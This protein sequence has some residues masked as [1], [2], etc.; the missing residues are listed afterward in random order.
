MTDLVSIPAV[1]Q[2]V[3]AINTA[4]RSAESVTRQIT[5]L[6]SMETTAPAVQTES[7]RATNPTPVSKGYDRRGEVE[8]EEEPTGERISFVA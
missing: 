2:P 4:Q 1:L 7:P 6:M 3:N 5:Q 8:K